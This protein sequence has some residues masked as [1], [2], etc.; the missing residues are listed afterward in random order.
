[1]SIT[2]PVPTTPGYWIG[3]YGVLIPDVYQAV[4]AE[5]GRNFCYYDGGVTCLAVTKP[6]TKEDWLREFAKVD[7]ELGLV[8]NVN[9]PKN[10]KNK[11]VESE[12]DE[13]SN[14]SSDESRRCLQFIITKFGCC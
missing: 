4:T 13:S 8:Y 7:Q 5:D 10:L 6:Y 12:S 3:P 14:E 9:H 2:D 1:M 11:V